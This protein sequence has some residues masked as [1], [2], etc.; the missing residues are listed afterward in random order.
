MYPLS[1]SLVFW[2]MTLSS[3]GNVATNMVAFIVMDPK[4]PRQ[5]KPLQQGLDPIAFSSLMA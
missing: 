4:E 5:V 3:K 1:L 2:P